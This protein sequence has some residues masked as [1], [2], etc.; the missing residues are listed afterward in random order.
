M[1]LDTTGYHAGGWEH[2]E[3]GDKII[4]KGSRRST[5]HTGT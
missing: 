3:R 4:G 1:C 5:E 2:D